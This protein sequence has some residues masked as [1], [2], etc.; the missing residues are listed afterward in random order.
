MI[1]LD[2]ESG[3]VAGAEA[4]AF[5]V[6]VFVVGAIIAVNG[7]AVLDAKLAA[8]TAAREATRTIVEGGATSRSTM[9]G[10][11]G[12]AARQAA[13][14][15]LDGMGRSPATNGLAVT[16]VDDPWR[17]THHRPDR[18]APVTVEVSLAVDGIGVPWLGGWAL[19]VTVTGTHTEYTDP[20]AS[21]LAGDATC[22]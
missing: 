19:P 16:L 18:C 14:A 1:D 2:G 4:L 11:D 17:T 22:P 15:V 20:F 13:L 6:L 9:L 12:G 10:E 5:G 3:I 8:S 21:G 7:W